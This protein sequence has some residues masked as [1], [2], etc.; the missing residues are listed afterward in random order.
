MI[1][2]RSSLLLLAITG[3]LLSAAPVAAD[4]AAPGLPSQLIAPAAVPSLDGSQCTAPGQSPAVGTGESLAPV[5]ASDFILCSCRYCKNHPDVICQISPTG[6]SIL[7]SDYYS[8]R[9]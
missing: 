3:L 1:R 2:L 6:F 9:C 4:T 7:C 8:S 5:P